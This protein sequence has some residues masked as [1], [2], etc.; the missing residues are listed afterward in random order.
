MPLLL[1]LGRR[2][3]KDFASYHNEDDINSL[4]DGRD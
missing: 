1:K 4:A 2:I 3:L